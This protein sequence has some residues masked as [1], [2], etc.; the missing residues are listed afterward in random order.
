MTVSYH[1]SF[2]I[3]IFPVDP[4]LRFEFSP[5]L[6][7]HF[8]GRLRKFADRLGKGGVQLEDDLLHAL[9]QIFMAGAAQVQGP[10]VRLE[11]VRLFAQVERHAPVHNR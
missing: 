4:Y 3:R 10:L 9:G 6:F 11:F 5:P 1:G 7:G 2:L 8:K